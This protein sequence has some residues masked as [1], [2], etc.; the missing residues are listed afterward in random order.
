MGAFQNRMGEGQTELAALIQMALKAGLGRT[1]RV[2]N[3]AS[4]AAGLV[5]EARRP[6][7]SFATDVLGILARRFESGMSS[8]AKVLGYLFMALRARL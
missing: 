5:M 2:D 8:A 3:S 7:A 4:S 1:A 6:M